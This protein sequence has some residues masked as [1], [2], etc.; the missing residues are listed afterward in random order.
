VKPHLAGLVGLLLTACVPAIPIPTPKGPPKPASEVVNSAALEPRE[1]TGAIAISRDHSLRL[2]KCTYEI[3]LDGE[4]L[5][6]LRSGEHVTIYAE[7]G[8]RTL[9]VSIRPDGKCKPALAQVP[10]R[11][12]ANATTKIRILADVSYDLRIEATT[13]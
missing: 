12:V 7:P 13:Y 10:L 3:A 11:V 4:T 6:G 5:A 2:L 9:G 1:G 8:E